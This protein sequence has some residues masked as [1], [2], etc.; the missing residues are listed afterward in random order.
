M[1]SSQ[2][3]RLRRTPLPSSTLQ[4][5]ARNGLGYRVGWR[6]PDFALDSSMPER[7]L[8]TAATG[9]RRLVMRGTS[10]LMT[11]KGDIPPKACL[12]FAQAAWCYR[13][14]ADRLRTVYVYCRC[15][16]RM[17]A[18][19]FPM[20]SQSAM[21]KHAG[22]GQIKGRWLTYMNTQHAVSYYPVSSYLE[23]MTYSSLVR[24]N[25]HPAMVQHGSSTTA[26]CVHVRY[27]LNLQVWVQVWHMGS[28]FH[29]K[30]AKRDLGLALPR[31]ESISHIAK[32]PYQAYEVGHCCIRF[33]FNLST[34]NLNL[35]VKRDYRIRSGAIKI[36]RY[37][38]R[39][40]SSLPQKKATRHG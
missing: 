37:R 19:G 12:D 34:M 10:I 35:F 17:L 2:A 38:C 40:L 16:P 13:L 32:H 36:F 24:A 1:Q 4:P 11:S 30:S 6:T 39:S 5:R 8:T 18:Q 22:L 7:F 26:T 25:Q 33:T 27:N 20:A 9:I 23:M 3:R 29:P 15:C 28:R 31:N 14:E 21:Q